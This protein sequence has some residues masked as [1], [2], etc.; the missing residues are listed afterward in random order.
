MPPYHRASSRRPSSR[1]P[2]PARRRGCHRAEQ[3]ALLRKSQADSASGSQGCR[4]RHRCADWQSVR[5]T[6]ASDSRGP[7]G[8]QRLAS[9]CLPRVAPTRQMP[10]G[11]VPDRRHR[12]RE[13]APRPRRE[14]WQ[15]VHPLPSRPR[16]GATAY[17]LPMARGSMPCAPH[18]TI[19]R[20]VRPAPGV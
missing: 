6:R 20:P 8:V 1:S 7:Y 17:H 14:Q 11:Y 13:G 15:M 10:D 9:L 19:A 12:A 2:I 4:H 16:P 3:R 18:A 5:E